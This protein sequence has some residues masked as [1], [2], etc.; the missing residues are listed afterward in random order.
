MTMPPLRDTAARALRTETELPCTVPVR[1]RITAAP[2]AP[3]IL[4][5]GLTETPSAIPERFSSSSLPPS[6][7]RGRRATAFLPRRTAAR[8]TPAPGA[9]T[10]GRRAA[11]RG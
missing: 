11:E 4:S 6:F 1:T 2:A 10:T 7:A 3:L 9:L 5:R 8:G